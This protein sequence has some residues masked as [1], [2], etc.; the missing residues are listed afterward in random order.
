MMQC[1]NKESQLYRYG[2]LSKVF[3]KHPA[4]L[5]ALAATAFLIT[6]TAVTQQQLLC[7]RE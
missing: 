3:V 5:T 6:E 7:N 4:A 1:K 2:H